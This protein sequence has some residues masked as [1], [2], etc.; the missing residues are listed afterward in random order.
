MSVYQTFNR[1]YAYDGGYGKASKEDIHDLTP[2]R[3]SQ[4]IYE[5][6]DKLFKNSNDFASGQITAQGLTSRLKRDMAVYLADPQQRLPPDLDSERQMDA[7]PMFAWTPGPDLSTKEDYGLSTQVKLY[8]DAFFNSYRAGQ[9][10]SD[11]TM[12]GNDAYNTN[13]TGKEMRGAG[14]ESVYSM[15]GSAAGLETNFLNDDNYKGN[16]IEVMTA[17]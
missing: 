9:L 15:D 5:D 10:Y 17:F 16:S 1:L 14:V 4:R 7:V 2:D 13:K 8:Q 11:P 12:W 6:D 3:W